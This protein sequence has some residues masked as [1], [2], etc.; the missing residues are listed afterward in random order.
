MSKKRHVWQQPWGY[1]ESFVIVAGLLVIGLMLDVLTSGAQ[2]VLP[3]WPLNFVLGLLF[4]IVLFAL[5]KFARN[6]YIIA[7]LSAIP[8]AIGAIALFTFLS[9][10]MGFIPQANNVSQPFAEWGFNNILGS[11]VFLLSAIYLLTTLGLVT[12]KRFSFSGIR[13]IGF[14]LN[15]FGLWLVVLAAGIGSG[16]LQRIQVPVYE[17]RSVNTGFNTLGYEVKLPFTVTLFDFNI[18]EFPAKI[19]FVNA[20]SQ[21]IDPKLKNNLKLAREGDK[22]K[23]ATYKLHIEKV[24][25]LAIPDSAGNF[26]LSN[27]QTAA[28]AVLVCLY[29]NSGNAVSRGWLSAGSPLVKPAY[30]PVD[31]MYFMALTLPQPRRFS[32][33]VELTNSREVKI[34]TRI[35]V[36]KPVKIEGW[37]LY[38]TGYDTEKGR[39]STLSVFEAV[40]D[41]WIPV[42]YF[43]IFMLL[44]GALFMFWLGSNKS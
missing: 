13:N 4:P 12:I 31:S 15:H 21:I 39:F 8:A 14:V 7:W 32:S 35:E 9:L 29:N 6:S 30:L 2:W 18:D 25:Q 34:N 44:A 33:H 1:T 10:C 43:G 37:K 36:N 24:L 20:H 27:N 26:V 22:F 5:F 28:Q 38:Q 23:I 11:W 40:R 17:G 19:A 3:K 16:D 41:P 42:V